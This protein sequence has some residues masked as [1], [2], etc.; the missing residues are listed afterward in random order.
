MKLSEETIAAIETAIKDMAI[1]GIET[2]VWR[3]KNRGVSLAASNWSQALKRITIDDENYR[4]IPRDGI[5]IVN[6]GNREYNCGYAG[7]RY[8]L[9]SGNVNGDFIVIHGWDGDDD[10]G[11]E[12][13]DI[14]QC[15][16]YLLAKISE[17]GTDRE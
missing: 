17:I 12:I 16:T 1:E 7:S 11:I 3:V 10:E 13:L 5:A 2:E 6:L 8:Y 15:P 9:V 4:F 14:G